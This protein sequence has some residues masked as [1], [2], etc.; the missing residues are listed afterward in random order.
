MTTQ[1]IFYLN[2]LSIITSLPLECVLIKAMFFP[3]ALKATDNAFLIPGKVPVSFSSLPPGEL[4]RFVPHM[5]P[6]HLWQV[7]QSQFF[8]EEL[9]RQRI[10]SQ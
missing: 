9:H 6:H 3:S 10:P 4:H 2:K 5:L 1:K 8:C 7:V